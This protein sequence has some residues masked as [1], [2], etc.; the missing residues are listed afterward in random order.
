MFR[1]LF[2][3]AFFFFLGALSVKAENFIAPFYPGMVSCGPDYPHPGCF[4]SKDSSEK[5]KSFYAADKGPVTSERTNAEG[6]GEAFFEYMSAREV[7]KYD[8]PGAAIGVRIY[9]RSPDSSKTTAVVDDIFDNLKM[10]MVQGHLR[11]EEYNTLVGKYRHLATRYYPRS[12]QSERSL[13]MDRIIMDRCEMGPAEKNTQQ[14]MEAMGAKAQELMT[15]GRQREALELLQRMG[16]TGQ[17]A[18]EN[19][20][21]PQG[22]KKWEECLEELSNHAYPTRVTIA[23]DPAKS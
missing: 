8:P 14:D 6:E 21:S 18:Y 13:S 7:N 23:P 10:L 16:Q 17:G 11:Q 22:V 1:K 4:L 20:I 19:S 12:K 3:L 15:Q 9:S 2:F 5:V